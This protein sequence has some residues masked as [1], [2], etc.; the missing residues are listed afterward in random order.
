MMTYPL[1]DEHGNDQDGDEENNDEDDNDT[2][3]TLSPVLVAL[4]EV[5]ESVLGASGKRHADGGHCV[6]RGFLR[7]SVR[8]RCSKKLLKSFRSSRRARQRGRRRCFVASKKGGKAK[9]WARD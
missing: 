8:Q 4:G 9:L 6:C 7:V 5:E 2:G 1:V 3:L